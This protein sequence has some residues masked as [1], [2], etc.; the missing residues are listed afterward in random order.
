MPKGIVVQNKESGIRYAVYE[1]AHDKASEKKVRDLKPGESVLSYIPK[2]A[3]TGED[4][5]D[6][7]DEQ[8]TGDE[9]LVGEPTSTPPT[10]PTTNIKK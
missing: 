2:L 5:N 3:P 10:Q 9:T 7:T 1:D 6:A 8:A 4:E